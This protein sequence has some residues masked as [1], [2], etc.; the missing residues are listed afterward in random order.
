LQVAAGENVEPEQL[1]ALQR[2]P[3]GAGVQ[4]PREPGVEHERQAPPVQAELQQIPPTQKPLAQ[5]APVVQE[6]PSDARGTQVPLLEHWSPVAQS[7]ALV[8]AVL[9]DAAPQAYG[10]QDI[11]VGAWQAPAPL[12]V[13]AGENVEPVQLAAPQ[14]VPARL[15]EQVPSLPAMAHE[16]Q[17]PVQALLQQT[18]LAQKPL[19]QPALVVQGAPSG[20]ARWA[21][22]RMAVSVRLWPVLVNAEAVASLR[23]NPTRRSGAASPD[24]D[25]PF[26]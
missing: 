12:Q 3:T 22:Q 19:A 16:A 2:V 14:R 5:L 9:Q 8:Q 17:V 10:A 15:G 20:D 4:V 21:A 24:I 26:S 13:A 7:A 1:A 18:P 11:V 6:A 25:A 23:K